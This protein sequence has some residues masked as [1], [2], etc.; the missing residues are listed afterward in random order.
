ML[1]PRLAHGGGERGE[2]GLGQQALVVAPG[3]GRG[4][5]GD[6]DVVARLA[7]VEPAGPGGDV[8]P[9]QHGVAVEVHRFLLSG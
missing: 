3:A 5:V 8:Q 2:G 6:G 7:V 9:D 1:R 4:F